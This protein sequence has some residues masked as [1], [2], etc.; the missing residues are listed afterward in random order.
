MLGL[1]EIVAATGARGGRSLPSENYPF[2]D[3]V[4]GLQVPL[5]Q[6]CDQ[7]ARVLQSHVE[8]NE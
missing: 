3:L 8:S 7:I 2:T 1:Y 6:V 5:L 4:S